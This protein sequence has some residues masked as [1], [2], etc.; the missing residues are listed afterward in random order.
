MISF[1]LELFSG[2]IEA[3]IR[4]DSFD[5]PSIDLSPRL[6]LMALLVRLTLG[7]E[8]R[9]CAVLNDS[10]RID[11]HGP[12]RWWQHDMAEIFSL[13]TAHPTRAPLPGFT[14]APPSRALRRQPWPCQ[15]D[16]VDQAW[17]LSVG[18]GPDS[19]ESQPKLKENSHA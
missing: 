14:V 6:F 5:P 16:W 10:V 13:S 3:V 4:K 9:E 19:Q 17:V 7:T 12:C 2:G 18:V 15:V 8:Q 11:V 1:I